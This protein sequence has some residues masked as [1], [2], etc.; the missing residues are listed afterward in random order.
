MWARRGIEETPVFAEIEEQGE[1]VRFPLL[2]TLR[3]D[4]V[5][6]PQA[7]LVAE[8]FDAKVRFSGV[9]TGREIGGAIFGGTAPFIG[10]A[11]LAATGSITP[12]ALYVLAG[13]LLTFIAVF[14]GRETARD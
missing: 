5:F 12:V 3:T 14:T 4:M 13:C 10:T 8:Q 6:A 11:L 7:A 2:H 1:K 9:S